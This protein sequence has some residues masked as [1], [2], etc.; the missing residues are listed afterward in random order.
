MCLFF[1]ST[2]MWAR[3]Y[4]L[5]LLFCTARAAPIPLCPENCTC[6]VLDDSKQ[7]L[8]CT[9]LD[10]LG[11]LRPKEAS[12]VSALQVRNLNL[13]KTDSRLKVLHELEKLDMSH[14]SIASL[15]N[16][17][18]LPKLT[19]LN[20]NHNKIKYI[21]A[22]ALPKTLKEIDVSSNYINHIP[23][24]FLD[25]KQLKSVY[26]KNNPISC[27]CDT[28]TVRNLM[29]KAGV[30]LS[31][32]VECQTP[33]EYSGK[34]WN[35]VACYTDTNELSDDMIG[36][37]AGSG[38]ASQ[39]DLGTVNNSDDEEGTE[40]IEPEYI[41][42]ISSGSSTEA[43]FVELDEGSGGYPIYFQNE[44]NN[45]NQNVTEKEEEEVEGSGLDGQ[46]VQVE[47]KACYYECSTPKLNITNS[48]APAPNIHEEVINLFNEVRGV[49]AE[50]PIE[51][52]EEPK[53]TTP[54][55]ARDDKS[56]VNLK[57]E[58]INEADKLPS[59]ELERQLEKPNTKMST[60]FVVVCALLALMV[61]LVVYSVYKR[62]SRRNRRGTVNK[63]TEG[64]ELMPICRP[65]TEPI[66]EKAPLMNGQNGTNTVKPLEDSIPKIDEDESDF[67]NI[68]EEEEDVQLRN[69]E[70]E[71][72]LTPK[73]E[74]VTI[75]AKE[76]SAP[77]TP[78]LV[79]RHLND[80]GSIITTPSNRKQ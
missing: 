1:R 39:P 78:V 68:V 74:R 22:E 21:S 58:I 31:D 14:N 10:F 44:T 6:S 60:T 36:D 61:A 65:Q 49:T 32:R 50:K 34:S 24:N 29:I 51:K 67:G 33:Y 75:Q 42:Q 27:T 72:L 7:E 52:E 57:T 47:P 48:T 79:N 30:T 41:P 43:P 25:L 5:W 2:S 71:N 35:S 63:E 19:S 77:K 23:K 4:L 9:S 38:E 37:E 80:D 28:I 64:K 13:F 69:K 54:A 20:V 59:G 55:T 40:E 46:A 12:S 8:A 73:M 45:A 53:I 56:H 15:S 66:S 11:K 18:N 76:L 17:P 16:F 3:P 62:R 26:L 70:N